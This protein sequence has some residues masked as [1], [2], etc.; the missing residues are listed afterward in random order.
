MSVIFLDVINSLYL[1]I[2]LFKKNNCLKSEHGKSSSPGLQLSC[3]S[4]FPCERHC[5]VLLASY[6]V[7]LMTLVPHQGPCPGK[8]SV[9]GVAVR[10][11]AAGP[12][13]LPCQQ[14]QCHPAARTGLLSAWQGLGSSLGLWTAVCESLLEVLLRQP[15]PDN[16]GTGCALWEETGVAC[17]LG[18]AASLPRCAGLWCSVF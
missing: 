17:P 1:L 15:F 4:T 13:G 16:P 5:T 3:I 2:Y 11:R 8:P 6:S 10:L 14:C 7:T 9:L 12:F 18:P